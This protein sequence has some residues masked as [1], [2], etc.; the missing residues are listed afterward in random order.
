MCHAPAS[1]PTPQPREKFYTRTHEHFMP[2]A[3]PKTAEHARHAKPSCA[4][5]TSHATAVP[6]LRPRI[7]FFL[8]C[9]RPW[10]SASRCPQGSMVLCAWP[11]TQQNT[12]HHRHMASPCK[13]TSQAK[14]QA[15]RPPPPPR[16]PPLPPRPPAPPPATA[17]KAC[18]HSLHHGVETFHTEVIMTF[19]AV[20]NKP[21]NTLRAAVTDV[22]SDGSRNRTETR[23]SLST[24]AP[25]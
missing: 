8:L 22:R 23:G 14:L 13:A 12:N 1:R 6:K 21:S 5:P 15:K 24:K 2:P 10:S 9:E 3:E 17:A 18:Q 11:H 4:Y 25:K 7:R 16:P 20:Q 19:F